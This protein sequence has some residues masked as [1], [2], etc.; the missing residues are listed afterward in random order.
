MGRAPCCEKMGLKKGPWTPDEDKVLVEYIQKNGHGSWRALPRQAGLLR[1][2]KSCRLRW[3]NYLRP[4]IKRGPFAPE[5]ERTIIQLHAI[6]GN[7]WSS[8]ASQLPGRTD[9]EIKNFWNTHL[10]K[11]LL[12]MGLDP[13]THAP[14]SEIPTANGSQESQSSALMRHM[15]QWEIARL[16]AEARLSRD[17]MLSSSSSS[18]HNKLMGN[19]NA[20]AQA[21]APTD[22]FLKLWNS[23][24]GKAFRKEPIMNITK[25]NN[26]L[27]IENPH[28]HGLDHELGNAFSW[29]VTSPQLTLSPV[30]SFC[31]GCNS[32]QLN[33]DHPDGF[34]HKEDN[35]ADW[36]G[37]SRSH[38]SSS[39][40]QTESNK[41]TTLED[42]SSSAELAHSHDALHNHDIQGLADLLLDFPDNSTAN[43]TCNNTP[44]NI[45]C[46]MTE[47]STNYQQ[48]SAW[49]WQE[50]HLDE[51]KDYWNNVLVAHA[52]TSSAQS[53]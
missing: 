24:A 38:D 26:N 33:I 9:N 53:S 13:S 21:K 3:T 16:E 11:K 36:V 15:S 39:R 27:N 4:D 12:R 44:N 37:I 34:I 31:S 47:L 29:T 22:L 42:S 23:E 6:L 14:K 41:P 7:R 50:L 40:G 49:A 5:E 52:Q 8:I 2:G 46:M 30:S 18:S 35:S 45:S 10:K 43:T 19:E 51:D 17:S 32:D 25:S 28:A 48:Q 20:E 1:C